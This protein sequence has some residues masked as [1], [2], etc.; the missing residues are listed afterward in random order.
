MSASNCQLERVLDSKPDE[1]RDKVQ[2]IN[3]TERHTKMRKSLG[4]KRQFIDDRDIEEV[5]HLFGAFEKTNESKIFPVEAFGYR[6]ITVERPL[7]LNFQASP[8]RIERFL[9]EKPIQ[10]LAEAEQQAILAACR[11]LD[12]ETLYCNRDAFTRR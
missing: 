4:S 2:L 7:R 11:T 10:K 9:D 1:R 6:R 12:E 5:V 8:E 3:A